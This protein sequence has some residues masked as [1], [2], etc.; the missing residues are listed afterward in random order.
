MKDTKKDGTGKTECSRLQRRK[1]NIREIKCRKLE[2]GT[3]DRK[4]DT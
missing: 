2:K 3:K 1:K 4:K